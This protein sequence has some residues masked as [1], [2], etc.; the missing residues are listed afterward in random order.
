MMTLKEWLKNNVKTCYY[1]DCTQDATLSLTLSTA[2]KGGL[3]PTRTFYFCVEHLPMPELFNRF[4]L[5]RQTPK[6]SPKFEVGKD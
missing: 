5:E 1:A 4:D 3:A 6:D 2:N